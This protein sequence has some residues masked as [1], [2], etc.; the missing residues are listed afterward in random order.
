M[1]ASLTRLEELAIKAGD[2][3]TKIETR[4]GQTV[5]KADLAEEIGALRVEMHK[6]FG[7]MVKWMVGIAVVLGAAAITVMTFVFNYATPPK[8]LP[9]PLA[10]PAP[11]AQLAPVIIQLPP[12]PALSPRQ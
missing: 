3:L 10:R 1:E 6:E 8:N 12:Y 11:A 2:R 4:L 5:T 7:G 9:A